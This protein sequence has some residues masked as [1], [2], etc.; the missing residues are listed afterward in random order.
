MLSGRIR[1]IADARLPGRNIRQVETEAPNRRSRIYRRRLPS[2]NPESKDVAR[3]RRMETPAAW[4][5]WL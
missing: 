4:R 3:V 5:I 1:P 2:P